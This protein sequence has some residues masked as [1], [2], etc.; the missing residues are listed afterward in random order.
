MV[1][2]DVRQIFAREVDSPVMVRQGPGIIRG[3]LSG[4]SP[5][6]GNCALIF[7]VG[8]GLGGTSMHWIGGLVSGLRGHLSPIEV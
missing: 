1:L 2:L 4:S 8:V 6:S 3:V 7:D 5:G